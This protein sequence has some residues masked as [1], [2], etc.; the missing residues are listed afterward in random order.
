MKHNKALQKKIKFGENFTE[1]NVLFKVV[2]APNKTDD[3]D[4]FVNEYP[5]MVYI[6]DSAKSFSTNDDFRIC[7]LW[8]DGVNVISK[9]YLRATYNSSNLKNFIIDCSGE[10]SPVGVLSQDRLTD[11]E[12]PWNVSE[13]EILNYLDFK[14]STMHNSNISKKLKEEYSRY[15]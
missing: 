9:Q 13:R 6:D 2:I 3:F 11:E 10:D 15:K 5:S 4:N 14:T 8:T 12:F 7:G 1:K